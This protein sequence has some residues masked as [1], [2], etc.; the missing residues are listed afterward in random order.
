MLFFCIGDVSGKGV[1]AALV[2]AVT[3]AMFRTVSA[4]E[5]SPAN[6]VMQLNASQAENNDSNMFVTLFVGTL[7]LNNGH[8]RYCNAG[9]DAPLLIG[10]GIGLLP[11]APN[12]PIGVIGDWKFSEQEADIYAGTTIFLYT[13]GLTE[14][15]DYSHQQ[16]GEDRIMKVAEQYPPT[17]QQLIEVMTQAVHDFV[18][19]AE[20]SDDLTMLA[21]KYK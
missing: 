1:P 5:S 12:L 14:A 20:Q 11:C 8:L 17:P 2:M 16:F 6:I 19:Q 18:G 13:D 9:H 10:Q 15:E 21:I 3:Q 4:H 7:N